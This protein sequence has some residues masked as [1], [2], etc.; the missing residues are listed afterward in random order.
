MEKTITE[1]LFRPMLESL[2]GTSN[3]DRQL[4]EASSEGDAITVE[5]TLA[6]LANAN[7]CNNDALISDSY[8][9]NLLFAKLRLMIRGELHSYKDRAL[10][11]A[12]DNGHDAVVELLRKD[13]DE[14]N[15]DN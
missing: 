14:N 6:T 3:I 15:G 7:A 10:H 2:I 1:I 5:C 8:N 12:I 4:I 9:G 13:M 11:V